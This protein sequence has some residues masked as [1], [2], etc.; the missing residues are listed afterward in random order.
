MGGDWGLHAGRAGGLRVVRAYA[1]LLRR[2]CGWL[3]WLGE[4][5]GAN[6]EG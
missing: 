2:A 1:P 4:P 6:V 5:T 3:A